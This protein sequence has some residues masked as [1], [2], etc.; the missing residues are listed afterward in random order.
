MKKVYLF[1]SAMLLVC[2]VQAQIIHVPGD[3]STIQQG[4]IAASPGDTVLVDEGIYYEQISF[5]GKKPLMV[6]SRLLMD[7][8]TS[9]IS[10]TIIDGSQITNSDTGSVVLFT[11]GEDTTSILYGFTVRNGTRG[12]KF[13]IPGYPDCRAGGGIYLAGSGWFLSGNTFLLGGF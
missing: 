10:N 2:A 6:A 12:T 11:S 5:L 3:F 13:E 1:F 4:I 8:D 9:H 7:G